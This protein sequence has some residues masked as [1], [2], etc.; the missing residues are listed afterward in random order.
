MNTSRIG[1]AMAILATSLPARLLAAEEGTTPLFSVSIGTT[2][3]TSIVFVL[4]LLILWKF[5]WGPILGAVEA[6]ESGIQGALDEAAA[7][8]AAAAALLEEHKAQ[9]ADARRQAQQI[10][11]EAKEAGQAVRHDIE[12]KARAEG[13]A[14]LER[15][16][17]EI[18][19]EKDAAIDELRRESV[20]IAL[21]AASKL[22]QEHLDSDKDRAL[23][24][25]YVNQLGR[26]SGAEA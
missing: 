18:G 11:A 20:D 9:M 6:R 4:L 1:V 16:K 21:A 3:W 26:D 12:E 8:Q 22:I 7:N 15:A 5:A 19:R 2:F 13:Q 17:A 24:L 14:M 10:I 23:V 25:G